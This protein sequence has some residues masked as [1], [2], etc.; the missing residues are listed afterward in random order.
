MSPKRKSVEPEKVF[1]PQTG[2]YVLASG[3]I[4]QMLQTKEQKR[5]SAS[6]SRQAAPARGRGGGRG[7]VRGRRGG[8]K[9]KL[10]VSESSD[11]EDG[12]SNDAET[13]DDAE[14]SGGETSGGETSGAETSESVETSGFGTNDDES[15]EDEDDEDEEE[16]TAS[17]R[18]RKSHQAT[19]MRG[20]SAALPASAS[21]VPHESKNINL[22]GKLLPMKKKSRS[23]ID[24]DDRLSEASWAGRRAFAT[25]SAR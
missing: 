22:C 2:R 16:Q 15:A 9:K 1:N 20:D 14:T 7:G 19:K 11:D 5:G 13:S 12:S 25:P 8:N 24:D 21:S 6:S 23:K 3:K 17:S 4:G 10:S 18:R